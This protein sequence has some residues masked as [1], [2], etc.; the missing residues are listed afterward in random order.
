MAKSTVTGEE[1]S[2]QRGLKLNRVHFYSI[3]GGGGKLS[4]LYALR[5]GLALT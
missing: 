2:S 3:G 5:N 4:W 1:R